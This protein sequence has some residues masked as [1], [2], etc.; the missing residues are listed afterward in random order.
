MEFAARLQ[1]FAHRIRSALIGPPP[2]PQSP[3]RVRMKVL[4]RDGYRCRGC[5]RPGDEITLQVCLVRLHS[6]RLWALTLCPS[7][8]RR[9]TE[10]EA[11][12][13]TVAEG[14]YL[15]GRVPAEVPLESV[16]HF[17]HTA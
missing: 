12:L 3:A 4:R 6:E 2:A 7:C 5:A 16:R 17:S 8:Q 9:A 14:H 13:I 11:G 10:V 1:G 15:R